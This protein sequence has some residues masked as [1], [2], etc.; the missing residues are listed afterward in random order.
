MEEGAGPERSERTGAGAVNEKGW[1][2]SLKVIMELEAWN[3][4]E[5]ISGSTSAFFSIYKTLYSL[6]V[7]DSRL[8]VWPI[9]VRDS[10]ISL[11]RPCKLFQLPKSNSPVF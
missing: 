4:N 8:L 11:E 2:G 9:L 6:M 5:Y 10:S 1:T 3:S 7:M